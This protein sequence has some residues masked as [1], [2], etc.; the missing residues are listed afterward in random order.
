[1]ART[2]LTVNTISRIGVDSADT[3]AAANVDG[4]Y[5]QNSGDVF[6]EVLNEN[7]AACTVTVQT[8]RTV[9]G[10]AVAEMAVVVAQ[11]ERMLIGPFP[12]NT[13]NQV[14]ANPGC[15]YVDFSAV[16]DV[17]VAAWRLG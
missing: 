15:I 1:M 14:S 2:T 4:H 17:T 9:D 13:F 11:D 8:P 6:L 7:V 16:A 10:L 5:V 3:L 12:V